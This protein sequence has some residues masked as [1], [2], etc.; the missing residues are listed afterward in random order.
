MQTLEEHGISFKEDN[1]TSFLKPNMHGSRF[2]LGS[3]SYKKL[4][5]ICFLCG[6]SDHMK[7]V[8]HFKGT[9]PIRP[10]MKWAPK[11]SKKTLCAQVCLKFMKEEKCILMVRVQDI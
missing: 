6:R 10:K 5:C 11:I 4:A 2:I 3:K 7:F 1:V 9:N 8:C